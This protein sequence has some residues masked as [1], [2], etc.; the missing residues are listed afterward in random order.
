MNSSSHV[1]DLG[2][3]ASAMGPVLRQALDPATP[4]S[5]HRELA[6]K[7]SEYLEEGALLGDRAA[8]GEVPWRAL[9]TGDDCFLAL[10]DGFVL[11]RFDA[12]NLIS[13]RVET[14]DGRRWSIRYT[15][16]G[17]AAFRQAALGRGSSANAEPAMRIEAFG[18]HRL[19]LRTVF[20]PNGSETNELEG[21]EPL[22]AP[23][24]GKAGQGL[25]QPVQFG[26]EL[27]RAGALLMRRA[28]ESQEAARR[29]VE[30][31]AAPAVVEPV[32]PPA[33][34]LPP[35]APLSALQEAEQALLGWDVLPSPPPQGPLANWR[36]LGLTGPLKG[37]VLTLASGT[38]V[39]GRD[40]GAD[41]HI[42][43]ATVSRRHAELRPVSKGLVL[44]DLGSANG[45][46]I[47]GSQLKE[48]VVLVGG[49]HFRLGE[50]AF[51]LER[52]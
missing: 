41:I 9:M 19:L 28:L 49:E 6:E 37:Q 26:P 47:A 27:I 32:R 38:T 23:L 10:E 17:L 33:P 2:A 20:H 45:T 24:P 31:V 52:A 5:A 8:D 43:N 13:L 21:L 42:E 25:E 16:R 1:L 36:L 39:L 44:E 7:V 14:F 48:P 51:L 50:C 30:P 18:D 11:A 12:A 34:A 40:P 35:P 15:G 29:S 22:A 4:A 46:W 3:W